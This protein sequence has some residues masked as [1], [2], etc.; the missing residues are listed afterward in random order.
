MDIAHPDPTPRAAAFMTAMHLKARETPKAE[1]WLMELIAWLS[2]DAREYREERGLSTV[3]VLVVDDY[4]DTADIGCVLL[5]YLGH[6]ATPAYTAGA[7]LE[8][9]K[10]FDYDVVLLDIGLPDPRAG[11]EVARELRRM[12]RCPYIVAV[13]GWCSV[14]ERQRAL[15]AG[16]HEWLP[17]P[18]DLQKI[19]RALSYASRGIDR[20]L[21]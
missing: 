7:A 2:F 20:G 4:V 11:H 17:K 12:P 18:V 5:N 16:C 8:A 14:R 1:V 6:E 9:A 3:K 15:N 21:P 13:T 10:A 19:K